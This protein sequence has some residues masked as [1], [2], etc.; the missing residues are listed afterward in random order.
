MIMEYVEPFLAVHSTRY[1]NK[2][3]L[4]H[5]FDEYLEEH[6]DTLGNAEGYIEV[7]MSTLNVAPNTRRTY[8]SIL[9]KLIQ[10][11]HDTDEVQLK[12]YKK[13]EPNF[14]GVKYILRS[15]GT[16]KKV[17]NHGS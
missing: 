6:C 12:Q 7:F 17:D 11:V 1:Y 5:E 16:Y 3:S 14:E 8:T 9:Y 4:Y 2:L 10:F 13:V 15:D